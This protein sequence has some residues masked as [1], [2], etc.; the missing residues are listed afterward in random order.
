MRVYRVENNEGNGPYDPDTKLGY[1][2][3]RS[4]GH[5]R[6]LR[7]TLPE[8]GLFLPGKHQFCG[9]ESLKQLKSWFKGWWKQLR[10]A[11]FSISVYEVPE[12]FVDIGSE[13]LLFIKSK[14][15]LIKKA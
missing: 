3:C 6:E 4:H 5:L 13:Q 7:P 8:S 15:I 2:I 11:G 1:R 12:E 10:K 9:C 14:A